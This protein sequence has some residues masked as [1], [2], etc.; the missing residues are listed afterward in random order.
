M[1]SGS[2]WR[3]RVLINPILTVLKPNCDHLRALKGLDKCSSNWLISTMNLQVAGVST[4][5]SYTSDK[6]GTVSWNTEMRFRVFGPGDVSL[7]ALELNPRP[8][9]LNP[10]LPS[11]LRIVRLGPSGWDVESGGDFQARDPGRE[12]ILIRVS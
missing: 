8:Y 4:F 12:S 3:F 11:T 2:T 7:G 9:T 5:C 10:K 1:G 6:G